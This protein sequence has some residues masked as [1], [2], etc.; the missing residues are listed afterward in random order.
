MEGLVGVHLT[1]RKTMDSPMVID[2][3]V[4]KFIG[5]RF[6]SIRSNL[7]TTHPRHNILVTIDLV[8]MMMEFM[9]YLNLV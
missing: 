5:H 3:Q 9:R 7:S 8:V 6:C 2:V 1:M 4:L